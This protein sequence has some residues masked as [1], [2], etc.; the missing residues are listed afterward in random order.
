MDDSENAFNNGTFHAQLLAQQVGGFAGE[1]SLSH[2]TMHAGDDVL[3]L[4][5]LPKLQS[6]GPVAA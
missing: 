3:Q 1:H 6:H 2:S 5:S 4:L